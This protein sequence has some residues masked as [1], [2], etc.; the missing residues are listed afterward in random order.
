MAPRRARSGFLTALLAVHRPKQ[1]RFPPFEVQATQDTTHNHRY[2]TR[3]QALTRRVHH[4]EHSPRI[5]FSNG[6]PNRAAPEPKLEDNETARN[7]GTAEQQG[8]TT[9]HRDIIY[10]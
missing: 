7:S 6:V 3:K 2:G 8:K 10:H 5:P 1:S 4:R 9:Q